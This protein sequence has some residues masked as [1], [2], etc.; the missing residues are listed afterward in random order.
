MRFHRGEVV[1]FHA[2]FLVQLGKEE[3]MGHCYLL[4]KNMSKGTK[5]E[6]V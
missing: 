5:V 6:C 1:G 4:D 3:N 2:E